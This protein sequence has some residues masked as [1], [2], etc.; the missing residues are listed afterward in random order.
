MSTLAQETQPARCLSCRSEIQ[1]PDTFA[2]GDKTQCGTCGTALRVQ[3]RGALRLVIADVEPLRL[4]V[5]SAQQRMAALES[6]LGRARASFGIGANGLGLGVLYVVAQVALEEKPLS[7]EL[8]VTATLIAVLTGVLL[9]LANF[10]FLAKRREMTRLSQEIGEIK[11]E[12]QD[13]QRKIRE[14]LRR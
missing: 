5:R 4:E 8:L 11:R 1:V 6:E 7:R 9:E 10:L 14:S 3:R 2:D 12:I 13:R